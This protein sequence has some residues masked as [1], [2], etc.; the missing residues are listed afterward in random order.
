Q[1]K[2]RDEHLYVSYTI[3]QP[4]IDRSKSAHEQAESHLAA[5]VLKETDGGIIIRG[6]QMLGTA[7]AISDYLF[8]SCIQ[9]LRPG[10][11]DYALS[12]AVPIDAPGLRLYARRGY[13][14]GQSS[15]FD[16]P[17]STRFDES[18]AL[19]VFRDVFVP[20]EQ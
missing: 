1:A 7:A 15:V 5:G 14:A 8:L 13:A 17:L 10:D 18:D 2:I 4:Q 19:V 9:P 20:W 11:E 16:Y 12:L 3:I 6:A